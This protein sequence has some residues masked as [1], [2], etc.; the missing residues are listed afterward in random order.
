MHPKFVCDPDFKTKTLP[1]EERDSDTSEPD[2]PQMKKSRK[3]CKLLSA[4]IISIVF[5]NGNYLLM[6]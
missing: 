5:Y 1:N 2:S 3:H 4:F 6:N